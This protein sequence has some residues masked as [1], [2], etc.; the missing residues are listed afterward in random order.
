MTEF[1]VEDRWTRSPGVTDTTTQQGGA[2]AA[3]V[4]ADNG[5]TQPHD[6]S[7]PPVHRQ[8]LS[9]MVRMAFN[10]APPLCPVDEEPR[11]VFGERCAETGQISLSRRASAG[12]QAL[13][14][15]T[16]GAAAHN[17][18]AGEGS[19]LCDRHGESMVIAGAVGAF[20]HAVLK[21]VLRPV[22]GTSATI[23]DGSGGEE[24]PAGRPRA[25][26]TRCAKVVCVLRTLDSDGR[27]LKLPH[28][29]GARPCARLHAPNPR[30]AILQAETAFYRACD[31][32][33]RWALPCTH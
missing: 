29:T 18:I 16:F 8:R 13:L 3:P 30:R 22:S 1:Y 2:L 32:G 33:C 11:P 25:V 26:D 28:N 7:S 19:V 15:T 20:E 24:T 23:D 14:P 6:A 9:R 21:G 12:G 5:A 10:A 27:G 4:M 31:D 17:V